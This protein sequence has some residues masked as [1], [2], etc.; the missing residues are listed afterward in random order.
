M[1][2]DG[3]S[4]F[5]GA[6]FLT[7]FFALYTFSSYFLPAF[8]S[9]LLSFA[10][11]LLVMSAASGV[12]RLAV[13]WLGF[14]DI[15]PSQK[16]LIGATLGLG[17]L[18]L[19]VFFIAAVHYLN[20]LTLTLFLSLLWILGFT[21]LKTMISS[22]NSAKKMFLNRPFES[23]LIFSSLL[24]TLWCCFTPPHQYDSLVYHLPLAAAYVKAH[25]LVNI[26]WLLYSHFP[27]NG[28]MLFALSLLFKS[29][30]LAQMFMWVSFFLSV[31]WIFEIARL[32]IPMEA[33]ILSILLLVTQ[34]SVMLLSTSSYVEPLVMLWTTASVLSFLRWEEI[35][36]SSSDSKSWLILSAIF[37]GL[38]LGTKYYAGITSGILG[39]ALWIRVFFSPS[40]KKALKDATLFTAIVTILFS[41]WMIKNY[42]WGGNP[43][44]PFFNA[45]FKNSGSGWNLEIAHNYFNALAEYRSGLNY[46]H[47]VDFP[48]MLLTN[49]LHFGRGM[50]VLGGLGWEILFWS[51]P[52]AIWFSR[53]NQFLKRLTA[54]SLL[55]LLIW[56]L[57]GVVLRFLIVLCPLLCLLAGN[58]FEKLKERLSPLTKMV[59]TSAILIIIL[60]HFLLFLFVNFG[61]FEAGKVLLGVESRTEYLS[62]KLLYYPCAHY[63]AM[64]TKRNDKILIMGDQRSYYA[65]A[66]SIASSIFS[67]NSF[68]QDSNLAQNETE[69]ASQLKQQGITEIAWVPREMARLGDSLGK[70]SPQGKVHL[71]ELF[72]KSPV[73]YHSDGCILFSLQ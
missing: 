5:L 71:Q 58:A 51:L 44:F 32:E 18:S 14:S 54:F 19:S 13:A 38:A 45:L 60:T 36:S 16:T 39:S 12:G 64:R 65:P 29:D 6:A 56:F 37:S 1:I 52:L 26:P 35:R 43:F 2:E 23:F 40:H 9:G 42:F 63:A 67:P 8:L 47:W 72:E 61:V 59:L 48:V 15:S 73:L 22:L 28:E 62:Q 57:T 11:L 46:H 53:K 41:P 17:I 24:L 50:D 7:L 27:Q 55:Y 25:G 30:I 21:E 4:L 20:F 70:L 68:I 31:W 34:T 66:G 49:S 69:L 10:E 3:K 33:V